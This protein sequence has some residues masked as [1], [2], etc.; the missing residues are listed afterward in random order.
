MDNTGNSSRALPSYSISDI[1]IRYMPHLKGI[2][3]ISFDFLINNLLDV[4]YSSNGYTYGYTYDSNRI[5]ENFY[6]PQAGLNF[7]GQLTLKF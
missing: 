3:G 6:Y 2:K 5:Q 1:R 7:I 4:E